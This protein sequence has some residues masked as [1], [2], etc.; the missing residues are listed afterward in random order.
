MLNG[1]FPRNRSVL[2]SGGPGTGKS[3]LAMQF[4]QKGFDEGDDCLF[5]ST[6][7]TAEE[8]RDSFEPFGFDLD[9]ESLRVVSLHAAPGSTLEEGEDKLVLRTFE[10]ETETF[11][12]FDVPFT[13]EYITEYLGEFGSHDRVVLDSASGLRVVSE[14]DEVY[15]RAVLDLI[16]LFSDEMGATAVFTS[17]EAEGHAGEAEGPLPF[18]THGVLNLW[19]EPIEGDFH[20]FLR[21]A[22]M[23]GVD[24][25]TRRV[26]LEFD[27]DGVRLAPE[28]RSQPPALKQHGH[29]S[30]GVGG[31]D[32]LCGGGIVRGGTVLLRHDGSANLTSVLA[33]FLSTGVER[34][35]A[36]VL[37][38]TVHLTPE[39]VETVVEEKN[40]SIDDLL[41]DD[42][43]F[44]FDMTGSWVGEGHENIFKPTDHP[45]DMK[46]TLRDIND[47][48]DSPRF[49]LTNTGATVHRLGPGGAREI[50]Y[51][52]D[53]NL[54]SEDVNINVHNPSVTDSRISEFFVDSAEQ[55]L[56]TRILDDGLQYISLSKSPC[57]FVG[58][59]SLVEFREEEPY[60]RIQ[61][62]PRERENPMTVD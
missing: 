17:A 30:I 51:F 7:Q 42:R 35:Y 60:F 3:T 40:E 10:D 16:R 24:H 49:Y 23:R 29:L 22:K 55:V 57:G 54:A 5:V 28:R 52:N 9:D 32:K 27:D 25:D 62:P 56:T 8:L 53:A 46:A 26:E 59:T 19:H 21:V 33:S 41:D 50:Q 47:R 1:G 61:N 48:V 14:N 4:L 38:P 44:V 36:L 34:G 45:S 2:V 15:R 31:L 13:A 20:K 58:S 12:D 43:L 6:E 18:T 39:R 37:T 11:R